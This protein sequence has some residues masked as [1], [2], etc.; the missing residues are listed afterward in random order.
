MHWYA[1]GTDSE[2]EEND[3]DDESMLV[4]CYVVLFKL[5]KNQWHVEWTDNA[6]A[7]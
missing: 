1:L 5:M 2:S 6:V 3:I 7:C 4:S